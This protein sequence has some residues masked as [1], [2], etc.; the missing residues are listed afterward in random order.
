MEERFACTQCGAEVV[1]YVG[2]D[3]MPGWCKEC[4]TFRYVMGYLRTL[5]AWQP[6]NDRLRADAF[7]EQ[8]GIMLDKKRVTC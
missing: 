7:S 2:D 4:A 8:S 1:P 3:E 6:L 5:A